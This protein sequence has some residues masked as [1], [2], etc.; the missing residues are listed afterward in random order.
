M[1]NP[2]P[3]FAKYPAHRV[4]ATQTPRHVRVLV[5]DVVIAD[6]RA[7]LE[8]EESRHDP[9]WYFPPGDVDQSVLTS[10]ESSTYCPFKG[11]ASYWTIDAAGEHLEDAVWAY[12]AP[13]DECRSLAGYFAFYRDRVRLEVDGE[14]QRPT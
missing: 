9:A 8:V 1:N 2:A 12:L 4:V 7:A 5:G 3:G 11:H 14:V 10:T 13:Y 6:T